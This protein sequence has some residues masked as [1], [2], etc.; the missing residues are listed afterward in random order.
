MQREEVC[1]RIYDIGIV[2]CARVKDPDQARFAADNLYAAGI[3]VIEIPLT[4]PGAPEVIEELTRRYPDMIVGAGTVLDQAAAQRSIDAGALYLT[5]PG[6][7]PEVVT[8]ARQAGVCAIPGALTPSEVIAGWK[9]GADFVKIFPAAIAGGPHYIR[10][11]EAPLPQI[12]L[13]ATGG[14][15]QLTAFDYILAGAHAIGVG[16]ELLPGEALENRKADRIRELARR[17]LLMVKEAR[18]QRNGD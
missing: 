14:V 17:F 3:P 4:V 15:N 9:A 5:S 8:Y 11:L 6:L 1:K 12:P 13:I 7:I 10:A 16:A 18:A 2:P